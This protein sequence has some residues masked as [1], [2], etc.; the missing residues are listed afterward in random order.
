[1]TRATTTVAPIFH[2]R[3]RQWGVVSLI[4]PLSVTL[5][6]LTIVIGVALG[7]LLFVIVVGLI[8]FVVGDKMVMPARDRAGTRNRGNVHN[9]RGTATPG[10]ITLFVLPNPI[11]VNPVDKAI[12]RTV[13]LYFIGFKRRL[14]GK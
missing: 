1:M 2:L 11:Q 3:E 5:S 6:L 9:C 13:E 4:L 14:F 7:S 8:E 12:G 10:K